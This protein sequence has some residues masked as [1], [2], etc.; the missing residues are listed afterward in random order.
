MAVETFRMKMDFLR[1]FMVVTP[2]DSVV[3]DK[4]YNAAWKDFEDCIQF[5]SALCV[6]SDY[7]VTRNVRDFE[8]AT[9]PVLSP[10]DACDLV[11]GDFP[12]A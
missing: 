7:I 12:V 9:I 3:V 8:R 1:R 11:M 10:D 4:A 5:Y 2:I 6:G